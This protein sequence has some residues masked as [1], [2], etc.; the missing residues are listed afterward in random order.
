[1]TM[2]AALGQTVRLLLVVS[3]VSLALYSAA[4]VL[5]VMADQSK[6][7]KAQEVFYAILGL[8]TILGVAGGLIF[9]SD[10]CLAPHRQCADT[11]HI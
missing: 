2:C 7:S 11:R 9:G 1:M 5:R 8:T 3:S 4:G 10:E 6:L